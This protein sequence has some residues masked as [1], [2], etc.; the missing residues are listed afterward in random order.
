MWLFLSKNSS[1]INLGE[2]GLTQWKQ[3]TFR[4]SFSP[5]TK[6]LT[7]LTLLPFANSLYALR[8]SRKRLWLFWPG[9][10]TWKTTPASIWATL[11]F[12]LLSSWKMGARQ[13]DETMLIW[14]TKRSMLSSVTDTSLFSK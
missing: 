8:K 14:S 1:K 4:N 6:P 9:S 12:A 3:K 11:M 2:T 5:S 13:S 10:A 7:S